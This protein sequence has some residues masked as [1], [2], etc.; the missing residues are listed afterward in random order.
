MNWNDIEKTLNAIAYIERYA[1]NARE[2]ILQLH[3]LN[4]HKEEFGL[5]DFSTSVDCISKKIDKIKTLVD[6]KEGL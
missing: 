1:N 3:N 5:P 4:I 2:L 6:G